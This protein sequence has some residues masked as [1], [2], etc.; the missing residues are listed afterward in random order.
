MLEGQGRSWFDFFATAVKHDG[1]MKRIDI[2]IDDMVGILDIPY[3]IKK[4][5]NEECVTIFQKYSTH[6]ASEMKSSDNEK[7][8]GNTLYIG[9]KKSDVYFCLYVRP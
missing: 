3:F 2:A 4:H 7:L 8:M 1:I 6:T 9:S 5:D